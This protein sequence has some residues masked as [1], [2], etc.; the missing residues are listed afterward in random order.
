[1]SKEF[2]FNKTSLEELYRRVEK[3]DSIKLKIVT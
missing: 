3:H 1:M 2:K